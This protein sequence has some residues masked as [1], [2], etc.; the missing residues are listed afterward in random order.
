M[1]NLINT[2]LMHDQR[3]MTTLTQQLHKSI[4]FTIH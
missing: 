1:G 4:L 2:E 3:E